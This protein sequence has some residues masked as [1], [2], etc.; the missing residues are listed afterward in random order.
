MHKPHKNRFIYAFFSWYISRIIRTDFKQFNY[1]RVA[2]NAQQSILLLSNHF[3]W[4]DGFLI[5]YLNRMFFKKKFHIMIT[6]E[7]YRKVW[8]LK[9]VGCFS[10]KKNSRSVLETLNYSAALLADPQNLVVIFPQGKL[11]SNHIGQTGFEKGLNHIMKNA[12]HGFQYLFAA[13][14]VDYFDNRKPSVTCYLA[15]HNCDTFDSL[16]TV[17]NAYNL[18]YQTSRQQQA[19]IIV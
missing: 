2:F 10:V 8:F 4:W 3:S 6:E 14:F 17:E 9:Y 13:L 7:N 5:F 1:N 18:H 19:G 16:K 11:Y 15:Q 12:D